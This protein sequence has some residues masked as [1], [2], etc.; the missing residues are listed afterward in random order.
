MQRKRTDDG[1]GSAGSTEDEGLPEAV[2]GRNLAETLALNSPEFQAGRQAAKAVGTSQKNLGRR[3]GRYLLAVLLAL[4]ALTLGAG[5]LV[6][7][8]A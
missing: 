4:M 6:A 7:V 8:F 5:L 3:T 1:P 2:M